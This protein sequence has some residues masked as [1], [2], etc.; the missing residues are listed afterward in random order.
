[1]GYLKDLDIRIRSGGDDAIAAACELAGLAKERRGYD[2]TM[3]AGED[4]T[5]IVTVLRSVGFSTVSPQ[6]GDSASLLLRVVTAAADEIERLREIERVW[7]P[8][9]FVPNV[10][11]S[12]GK[13]GRVTVHWPEGGTATVVSR[14]LLDDMVNCHNSRQWIPVSERLPEHDS[15]V[16]VAAKRDGEYVVKEMLFVDWSKPPE[17]PRPEWCDD[18]GG[19]DVENVTHWMP[20]PAPPEVTPSVADVIS[21][22]EPKGQ[23]HASG[24]IPGCL[25]D[26]DPYRHKPPEVK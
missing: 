21:H 5:D 8:V 3:R 10:N 7:F 1:M 2:E 18:C 22:A 14:E 6:A 16:L 20:L 23:G 17:P 11:G 12:R 19:E 9:G 24:Q 26:H 15:N 13:D 4:I 25:V